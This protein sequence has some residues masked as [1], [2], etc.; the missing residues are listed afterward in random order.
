MVFAPGWDLH[1]DVPCSNLQVRPIMAVSINREKNMN[2]RRTLFNFKDNNQS[3]NLPLLGIGLLDL[4]DVS[5]HVDG[6]TR[7]CMVSFHSVPSF[8]LV[9]VDNILRVWL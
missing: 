2:V 6:E 3:M 5:W 9:F 4:L 8:E 1:Q 7:A